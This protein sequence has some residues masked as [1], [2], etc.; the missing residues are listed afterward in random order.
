MPLFS[1]VEVCEA[2]AVVRLTV[3]TKP[4]VTV[5]V[6]EPLIAP[7]VASI[8][9][10][11]KPANV[12]NPCEPDTLLIVATL[13]PDELHAAVLVRVCVLASL[14]VPVA[15]NGCVVPT[16]IEAFPG[17]TAIDTSTAA[18]TVSVVEPVMLPSVALMLEAPFAT[19]VASPAALIVA[20]LGPDELHAAVLVR[21]CVLP[22]LYVPVAVNCCVVPAPIEASPAAVTVTVVEPV[23]LPSVALMLEVP[24]VTPV[25]RPPAVIIATPG[26]D[27]LQVAD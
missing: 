15:V 23:M 14:Y 5:N 16:A 19:L 10:V 27:E 1:T 7:D 3:K 8:V 9:V 20:T 12:A 13:G 18:V 21:V 26:A 25:D 6:V 24:A 11:P 4:A 2:R 17:V 22:S